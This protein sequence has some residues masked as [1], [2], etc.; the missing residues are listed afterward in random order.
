ML[1]SV[2]TLSLNIYRD[3][4]LSDRLSLVTS[5]RL[6]S[7]T[8]FDV[9]S[10]CLLDVTYVYVPKENISS[11]FVKYCELNP[12]LLQQNEPKCVDPDWRQI[13]RASSAALPAVARNS[14]GEER[15]ELSD[16]T[17][18]LFI[19]IFPRTCHSVLV[20]TERR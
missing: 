12:L 14:L 7:L 13:G 10:T 2:R 3:G 15:C 20:I 5:S 4:I 18:S 17:K 16:K 9:Q 19:L 1:I 11:I 6:A 8:N